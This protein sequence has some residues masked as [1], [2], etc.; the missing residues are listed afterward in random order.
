MVNQLW[1]SRNG[2][3]KDF[4]AGG[5]KFGWKNVV[6]MWTRE[7]ERRDTNQIRLVPGMLEAYIERDAWT[8]L[9]VKPAK[10]MQVIIFHKFTIYTWSNG[11]HISQAVC[12]LFS[13]FDSK[14]FWI[15]TIHF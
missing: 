6:D 8:K 4:I 1:A 9:N 10:I 2:G 7:K 12:I 15:F 5:I 3:A 11:I 13:T 14:L